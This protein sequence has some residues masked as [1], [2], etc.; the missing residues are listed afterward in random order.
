MIAGVAAARGALLCLFA[1][2]A[3]P[4]LAAEASPVST[5]SEPEA[6]SYDQGA[7]GL[8]T[9]IRRLATRA[10]LLTIVAHPDDEDGNLLTYEARGKG[11]RVSILTL[12]R[13]EGGKNAM[14]PGLDDALGVIR[15]HETLAAGRTYGVDQVWGSVIDYGFSKSAAEAQRKWGSDRALADAVRAIRR[16]RPL[17]VT[18]TFVGGPSDGHGHHQIAGIAAQRAFVLA[19]DPDAFPE[20]IAQEGLRPW[21]PLKVYGHIPVATITDQGMV[22]YASGRIVPVRFTNHVDGSESVGRLSVDV[23]VDAGQYSALPGKSYSQIAREGMRAHRSQFPTLGPVLRDTVPAQYHRFGSRVSSAL[24]ERGLFDGIDV[25][26]TGLADLVPPNERKALRRRLHRLQALVERI[27]AGFDAR[28]PDAVAPLLAYG[29]AQVRRE[30]A[31]ARNDSLL[32]ELDLKARQFEDALALSLGLSATAALVPQTS[33][34]DPLTAMGWG[35]PLGDQSPLLTRGQRLRVDLF[36]ASQSAS[37]VTVLSARPEGQPGEDW[38]VAGPDEAPIRLSAG[39]HTTRTYLATVPQAAADTRVPY[40]RPGGT[41]AVYDFVDPGQRGQSLGPA[42]LS[43]L[44]RFQYHGVTFD[45]RV[46]VTGMQPSVS[47]GPFPVPAAIVPAISVAPTG[48]RRLIPLAGGTFSYGVDLRN[49]APGRLAGKAALTLPPGWSASPAS[50]PFDLAPGS[51]GQLHF[52]VSTGGPVKAGSYTIAASASSGGNT[53][54]ESVTLAGYDGLPAYPLY[55][56]AS[57]TISA[58]DVAVPGRL[59]VAYVMG[60]GDTLP[61]ALTGLGIAV[62]VLSPERIARGS[63]AG[64]DAVLIG[65]G[66]Y[67]R[68][69]ELAQAV[70]KLWDY[71]RNGGT[72]VIQG[73]ARGKWPDLLPVPLSPGETA[74]QVTEEDA[75]VTLLAPSDPLLRFPNA[76]GP[77]DFAGWVDQ[78]GD[79]FPRAWPAPYRALLSMHD[80]DQDAQDGAL[81]DLSYGRG[82]FVYTALAFYRQIPAGVPGAT[83]LL[84]NL[85]SR[86]RAK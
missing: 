73:P 6:S 85:L 71:A 20:Q 67:G 77:A 55:R 66:A 64:Y 78:R 5:N 16:L 35:N 9:A 4:L 68:V 53:F 13:G 81:L 47:R 50:Q 15:T 36:L 51:A 29:L 44:A 42:P 17:I 52:T 19:G 74:T 58:V 86:S 84:V 11:T 37:D 57:V 10:S 23:A 26:L 60:T 75:A 24:P 65:V 80:Q 49:A 14:G 8:S 76:I 54:A 45:R 25:T 69:A 63:F 32:F 31:V 39:D 28:Q 82:H 59:S 56:P 41:G 2:A 83:R 79:G 30:I 72:V 33:R 46:P 38:A 62:D 3:A 48:E 22:D 18:S 21:T 12:T 43:V 40:H 70:P 27:D 61:A 34:D 7:V 1:S